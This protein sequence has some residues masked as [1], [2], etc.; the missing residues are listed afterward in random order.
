MRAR[1]VAMPDAHD[2]EGSIVGRPVGAG[3]GVVRR[4]VEHA[5]GHAP[6][7]ATRPGPGRR[8][9]SRP[10]ADRLVGAE[11]GFAYQSAPIGTSTSVW[12]VIGASADGVF[13]RQLGLPRTG[14]APGRPGI[15]LPLGAALALAGLALRRR[16]QPTEQVPPSIASAEPVHVP[17]GGHG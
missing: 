16:R 14:D 17:V 11:E 12:G 8:S 7:G 6:R 2:N 10:T 13:F 3:G 5:A 9:T 1:D 15:D 4:G